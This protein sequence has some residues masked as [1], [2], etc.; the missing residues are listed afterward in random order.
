MIAAFVVKESYGAAKQQHTFTLEVIA[1]EG[2]DPI[3]R[4]STIRRKGRNIYRNGTY[5]G[6]WGDESARQENLS[7]KYERGYVARQERDARKR[8]C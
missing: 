1:S 5:R 4:G 7:E 8:S 2:V 3:E 6:M